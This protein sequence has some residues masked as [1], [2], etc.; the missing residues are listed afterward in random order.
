[1]TDSLENLLSK[2]YEEFCSIIGGK[3][4]DK[5][6]LP[7]PNSDYYS[8]FVNGNEFSFTD[9]Q[10]SCIEIHNIKNDGKRAHNPR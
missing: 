10:I 9:E 7:E 6:Y 3:I 1:M 2:N 5:H 4:P 8:V